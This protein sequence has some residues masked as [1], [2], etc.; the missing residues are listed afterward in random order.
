V[1][2][3]GAVERDLP[4]GEPAALAVARLTMKESKK[5]AVMQ[6]ERLTTAKS[7]AKDANRKVP[8]SSIIW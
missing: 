6:A 3:R 7:Y 8:H 2:A 5:L 4:C 1:L